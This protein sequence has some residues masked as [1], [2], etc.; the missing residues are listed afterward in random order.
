M[1]GLRGVNGLA[2]GFN[3]DFFKTPPKDGL[4]FD[5]DCDGVDSVEFPIELM[6][7]TLLFTLFT[8]CGVVA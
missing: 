2:C 8:F 6:V 5:D 1:L 4:S 3:V 7:L